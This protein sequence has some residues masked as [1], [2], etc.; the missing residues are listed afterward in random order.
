M[1]PSHAP[2]AARCSLFAAASAVAMAVLC[3]APDAH[4]QA[5]SGDFAVQRFDPAPGVHNYFTTRGARTDGKMVWSLG[6]VANYSYR[7]F[8]VKSCT[9]SQADQDLG[10]TCSDAGVAKGVQDTRVIENEIT[11]D[12]LGTLTPIPRLQ[13]GLKVPVS[14]VK[15]QGIDA[16]T[17]AGN[18]NTLINSAGLGDAQ[19]EAK[20]RAYGEPTSPFVL[21]VAGFVTGPLGHA[22]AKNKYIGD[23]LPSAGLRLI[24]D[25]EKGPFSVGANLTGVFRDKGKVGATT[26]GSEGRYSVAAGYRIGPVF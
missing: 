20:F 13:L 6:L 16:R 10:K 21:G 22:T 9:V 7:P 8:E 26:V 15:G 5:V 19:L 18:K 3:S 11:G 17:G 14:W 25:G 23:T 2:N 12:L 1:S 4:A 24:I